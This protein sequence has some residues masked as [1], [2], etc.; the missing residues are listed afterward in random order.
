[1]CV[2]PDH[3]F[4]GT[5]LDNIHD[6]IDKGRYDPR[7]LV[8]T[9]VNSNPGETGHHVLTD[10]AVLAIRTA[11]LS[12]RGSQKALAQKYGVS[13]YAIYA[14]R[15]RLTWRHLPPGGAL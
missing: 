4:A 7:R 14:V 6:A 8:R 9:G 10:A 11:D 13:K 1:L 15:Q 5:V 2:R 3:L 12:V